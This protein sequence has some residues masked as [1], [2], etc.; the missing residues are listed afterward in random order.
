[1]NPKQDVISEDVTFKRTKCS[2]ITGSSH[3]NS[4]SMWRKCITWPSVTPTSNKTLIN[5]TQEVAAYETNTS[6]LPDTGVKMPSFNSFCNLALLINFIILFYYQI[7]YTKRLE[8]WCANG[9]AKKHNE[10]LW[11]NS[12]SFTLASYS[13]NQVL[14]EWETNKNQWN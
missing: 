1:M 9:N 13:F 11:D 3:H 4:Y 8:D 5:F 14:F 12:V 10:K 7:P 2:R 6:I